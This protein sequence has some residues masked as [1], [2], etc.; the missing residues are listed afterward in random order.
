[1]RVFKANRRSQ[2]KSFKGSSVAALAVLLLSISLV[3][4]EALADY[5]HIR[6]VE[7]NADL[8]RGGAQPAVAVSANYPIQVGDQV[9]VSSGGRTEVILPDGSLLRIG[10]NSHL[11][12]ARLAGSAETMD[13]R[14][15]LQLMQGQILVSP[16]VD[17]IDSEGFRIDMANSS[18]FL[19]SR[20]SYRIFTD[21]KSWTQVVVRD[22][23]AKVT[24]ERDS[25][26]VAT[27]Q[28]G[29]VD[30]KRSPRVSVQAAPE[31][32]ELEQWGRQLDAEGQ[33]LEAQVPYRRGY[34]SPSLSYA[35]ASLHRHGRW[36]GYRGTHVWRP[37]VPSGWRPYHSGWW[38]HTAAGLTWISTESWG[39]APYHYGSWGFAGGLG[40]VWYPGHR[41]TPGSVYWYWG[42]THVGWTPRGHDIPGYGSRVSA[43]PPYGTSWG[44]RHS[45]YSYPLGVDTYRGGDIGQWQDWTFSPH[46]RFGYRDSYRFLETGTDLQNRGVFR[47]GPPQGVVT[48]ETRGLTPNLWH[49]PGRAQALLERTKGMADRP[50]GLSRLGA[51]AVSG[52]SSHSSDPLDTRSVDRPSSGSRLVRQ[53]DSKLWRREQRTR[54]QPV[55]PY[56]RDTRGSSSS[57]REGNG[58]PSNGRSATKRRTPGMSARGR[59]GGYQAP[60]P[61]APSRGRSTMGGARARPSPRSPG[62]NRARPSAP[63]RSASGSSGRISGS[64][65]PGRSTS[66]GASRST[67]D[68]GGSG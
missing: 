28:Q 45:A 8:L 53:W 66:G 51:A 27:G 46:D 24:T 1:M 15:T 20:G 9:F 60:R 10:D 33:V 13:D 62:I 65:R 48:T 39:W 22:G 18:I 25:V 50:G 17:P 47:T 35:A 7:G 4:S 58:L 59:L 41:Y 40:W 5:G 2:R 68:D 3:P 56:R 55:V 6:T 11:R 29:L 67:S 61:G 12:F 43:L 49:D 63:G 31:H 30:G 42:P 21:G 57:L 19:L 34:L 23:F 26:R 14:N 32:D 36:M 54:P 64:G 44:F 16:A 38:I 37:H 52:W